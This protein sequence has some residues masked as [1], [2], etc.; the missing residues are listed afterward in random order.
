MLKVLRKN[1]LSF[2]SVPAE[3]FDEVTKDMNL[4]KTEALFRNIGSHKISAHQVFTKIIK[5]LSQQEP[6]KELTIEDIHRK[7]VEKKESS[8]I[9]VKGMDDVLVTI[10]RCC[11][12]VPGD[13]IVGYITRGKG[14]S[15]HRIDCTNVNASMSSEKQRFIDV[16]WDKKAPYKFNTEI[17]IDALDR[18]KL[19]RDITNIISEYDLNIVWANS[20]RTD[21]SG[22]IKFRFLIEISNKYILKD[23]INNIKQIDSVYDAYRILPRK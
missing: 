1:G 5:K 14:I 13:S 12:P 16:Y 3:V 22:H 21:K 23:V 10:A 4:G 11:N 15:V 7:E 17:Q 18:T 20:L 8:G 19:L 2:K 6:E 9:K